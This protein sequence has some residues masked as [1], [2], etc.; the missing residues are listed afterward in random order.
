MGGRQAGVSGLVCV[1][2]AGG[3]GDYVML[4]VSPT[5]SRI[6]WERSLMWEDPAWLWIAQFPGQGILD[7]KK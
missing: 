5:E 1:G 4:A 2:V 7:R 6:I 3:E